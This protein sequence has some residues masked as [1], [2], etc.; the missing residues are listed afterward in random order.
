[1][2]NDKID[3]KINVERISTEDYLLRGR[4]KIEDVPHKGYTKIFMFQPGGGDTFIPFEKLIPRSKLGQ[5]YSVFLQDPKKTIQLRNGYLHI[6][7]KGHV[8]LGIAHQAFDGTKEYA[9]YTNSFPLFFDLIDKDNKPIVD[10]ET[11]VELIF[12]KKDPFKS[13]DLKG[14]LLHHS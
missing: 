2:V 1:M 7:S 14:R 9:S 4:I 5:C 6:G 3:G 8:C 10:E 12:L 13:I 11:L